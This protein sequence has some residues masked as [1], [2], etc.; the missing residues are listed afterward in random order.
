MGDFKT[1][2]GSKIECPY[3]YVILGKGSG[4]FLS[5]DYTIIRLSQTSDTAN[6]DI[7]FLLKGHIEQ[8]R[9]LLLYS[10]LKTFGE[11]KHEES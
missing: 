1:L 11:N 3:L 2:V 10:P 7:V 4:Q 5:S 9:T 8:W 6:I